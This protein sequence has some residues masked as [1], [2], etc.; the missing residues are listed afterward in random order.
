ME[1]KPPFA[2]FP[3]LVAEKENK[4]KKTNRANKDGLDLAKQY[5]V[6]IN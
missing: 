4:E 1:S 3:F 5:N 6:H 2:T